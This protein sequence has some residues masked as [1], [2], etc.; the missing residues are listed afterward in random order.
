[1]RSYNY[2]G[3]SCISKPS[4]PRSLESILSVTGKIWQ[5][6]SFRQESKIIQ[7]TFELIILAA[8]WSKDIGG[9]RL[10][11]K[12]KTKNRRGL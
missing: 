6:V 9:A 4:T 1:M 8:V 12:Q 5:L 10:E 2:P 3:F 11:A 7:F